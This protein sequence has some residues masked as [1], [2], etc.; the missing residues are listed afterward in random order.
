MPRQDR[1]ALVLHAVVALLL[2]TTVAPWGLAAAEAPAAQSVAQD[3][4]TVKVA[5]R[6]PAADARQWA[7]DVTLDTH[8]HDLND[9]LVANS[10][11]VVDGVKHKAVQWSGAAAGGHHRQGVLTFAAP[12][13]PAQVVELRI[14]RPNESKPRVFR[15]DGAAWRP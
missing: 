1:V 7:F 10:V 11:L 12:A 3:G 8:S 9:D 5:P 2:S 15:W 6:T 14:L 13:K 4:V